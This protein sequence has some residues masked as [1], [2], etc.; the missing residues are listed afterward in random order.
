MPDLNFDSSNHKDM[1]SYSVLPKGKY[2]MHIISSEKKETKA[3][4]GYY[5]SLDLEVCAG[6]FKGSKVFAILN[7]W[8]QNDKAVD[9]ANQELATI[10]RAVGIL[11]P[12]QSEALHKIPFTGSVGIEPAKGDW[13]EKNKMIGYEP[14]SDSE[15]P[16]PPAGPLLTALT[17]EN[18]VPPWV[19]TKEEGIT[20]AP[21][22]SFA[23]DDIPY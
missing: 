10:C 16:T 6:E 17:Q 23:E 7:L 11:K 1:G 12:K 3:Q 22:E 15:G 8:N 14:Y 20:D 4:D 9:M 2:P 21:L 18:S 19:Q 5:L 13:P